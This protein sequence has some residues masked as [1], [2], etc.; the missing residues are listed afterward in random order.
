V[1]ASGVVVFGARVALGEMPTAT[2]R[3]TRQVMASKTNA[4]GMPC[5]M[6]ACEQATLMDARWALVGGL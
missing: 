3:V 2:A 6:I 1:V 4:K 5:V